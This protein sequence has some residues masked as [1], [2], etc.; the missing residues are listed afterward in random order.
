[1]NRP[2][3]VTLISCFYFFGAIILLFIYNPNA[4]KISIAARW[5]L[6]NAAEQLMRVGIAL[7]SMIIGY[8]YM[9]LKNGDFG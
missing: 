3:G 1:M 7:L 4:N 9:N 6:L 8:G 5:G 2:L